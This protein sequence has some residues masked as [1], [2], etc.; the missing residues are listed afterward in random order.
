MAGAEMADR[1]VVERIDC[2]AVGATVAG[3]GSPRADEPAPTNSVLRNWIGR[4]P[5]GLPVP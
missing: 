3:G 2:E 1:R 5:A 4:A